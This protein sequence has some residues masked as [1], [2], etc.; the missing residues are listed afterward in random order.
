[1]AHQLWLSEESKELIG[2]KNLRIIDMCWFEPE[3]GK[4]I[5]EKMSLALKGMKINT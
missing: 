2:W 4:I 3:E 5:L 1:V